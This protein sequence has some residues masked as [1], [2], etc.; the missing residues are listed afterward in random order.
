VHADA[1]GVVSEEGRQEAGIV[2]VKAEQIAKINGFGEI[3]SRSIVQGLNQVGPTF[4]HM[5]E[6]GFNLERTPLHSES[7]SVASPIAGKRVVFSGKM[8]RGS[9]EEMKKGARAL[10]AVVQSAV[11]ST[12]D[13]LVCGD[14]V[15]PKK[16]DKA[17]RLG[18]NILTEDEYY[19]LTD[20]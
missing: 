7:E 5:M 9:R 8:V 20:R 6:L 13:Y 11:S 2:D 12:T 3:T 4:R 17:S 16:L 1:I 19:G 15:G 18:V 10:G 14:N